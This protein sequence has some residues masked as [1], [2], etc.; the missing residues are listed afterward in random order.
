MDKKTSIFKHNEC[1]KTFPVAPKM[2]LGVKQSRCPHCAN[3][4]RGG[5]LRDD[6]Y[7]QKIL[8][9]AK[10]GK[11]YEWLQSYNNDNKQKLLIKHLECNRDYRVRPNDF[12]QG[13]RC[14]HCSAES[15]ESYAVTEI[16]SILNKYNIKYNEEVTFND[17][18]DK[19]NLRI[20]FQIGRNLIEYDGAQHFKSY[21]SG[22]FAD[23]YIDIRKRDQIKNEWIKKN[24]YKFI[25]IP[26]T[27]SLDSLELILMSIIE[28]T[29]T[30]TLI[31]HYNLYVY[32][33]GSNI[34]LNEET[35]YTSINENYFN[36]I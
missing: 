5:Y 24:S 30:D 20:D 11:D 17:L 7:L 10:D 18:T 26:Y 8:D 29:L 4:R 36:E 1:G 32:K 9:N 31:N 25:R 12:Q 6:N 33:P 27:V 14:P 34:V 19:G 15:N 2:F 22:Y 28:G 21:N 13:Y 16:K 3:K 35:Y 23:K